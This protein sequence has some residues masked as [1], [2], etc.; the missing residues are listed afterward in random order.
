MPCIEHTAD[1]THVHL[2]IK[3]PNHFS[4]RNFK[5]LLAAKWKKIKFSGW[6]NLRMTNKNG[7]TGWYEIIEDTET[8]RHKVTDYITKHVPHD[9]STVD[10]ENVVTID[11]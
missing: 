5:N 2:V 11:S 7:L 1:A 10:F 4:H 8:D 6:S 3:K 9:F